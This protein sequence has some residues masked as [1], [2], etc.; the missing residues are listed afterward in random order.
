MLKPNVMH[1]IIL[2]NNQKQYKVIKEW[3]MKNVST[4]DPIHDV[5]IRR[6]VKRNS[7]EYMMTITVEVASGWFPRQFLCLSD[8]SDSNYFNNSEFE[9]FLKPFSKFLQSLD[10]K[11]KIRLI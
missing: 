3:I 4:D 11:R 5:S 10:R 6:R 1:R 7:N 9:P 2:N 8:I